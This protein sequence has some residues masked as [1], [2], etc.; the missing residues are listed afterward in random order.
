MTSPEHSIALCSYEV[1]SLL[2]VVRAGDRNRLVELCAQPRIRNGGAN[3]V[4][5]NK[6]TRLRPPTHIQI[7]QLDPDCTVANWTLGAKLNLVYGDGDSLREIFGCVDR[8]KRFE[9]P[10]LRSERVWSLLEARQAEPSI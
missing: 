4:L 3:G 7:R 2:V 9:A 5:R 6:N 8:E 1:I 10:A